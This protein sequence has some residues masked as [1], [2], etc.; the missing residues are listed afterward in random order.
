M[1]NEAQID[2]RNATD[3]NNRESTSTPGFL[4]KTYDMVENNRFP[5]L[6]QWSQ[7]GDC[8]L[9]KDTNLFAKDVLPTYF[10]HSNYTSFVRQLNMYGFKKSKTKQNY[11]CFSHLFFKRGNRELL[12]LIKRRI[13]N[14]PNSPPQMNVLPQ[15]TMDHNTRFLLCNEILNLKKN[16]LD[17]MARNR[18]LEGQVT[19]ASKQIQSM[20][21]FYTMNKKAEDNMKVLM[22][23]LERKFGKEYLDNLMMED[24]ETPKQAPTTHFP[25]N[26]PFFDP[27]TPM[28]LQLGD[29]DVCFSSL[30]TKRSNEKDGFDIVNILPYHL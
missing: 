21:T 19:E 22:T 24:S 30:L 13:P 12:S 9:V 8:L 3:S 1:R 4:L 18:W 27:L 11:D 26:V 16:N 28:N 5:Q 29:N 10:K 25:Q 7:E 17:L 2:R 20:N 23:K 6:V 14:M 15:T